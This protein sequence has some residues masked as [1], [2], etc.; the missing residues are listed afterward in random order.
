MIGV[1]AAL[2]IYCVDH[3]FGRTAANHMI[4]EVRRQFKADPGIMEGKSKP[5]YAQCVDISTQA[6]L[7]E[8]IIPGLIASVHQS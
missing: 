4:D 2:S 7:H 1:D 3:S 6:A 5:D 8:M